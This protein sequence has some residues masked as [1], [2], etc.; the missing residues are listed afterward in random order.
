MV[1]VSPD[2]NVY[3]KP[4]ERYMQVPQL[5]RLRSLTREVILLVGKLALVNNHSKNCGRLSLP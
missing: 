1:K 3:V 2:L 4:S 5:E